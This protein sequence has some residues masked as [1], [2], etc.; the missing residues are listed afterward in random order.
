MTI[1][2]KY[3]RK[4]DLSTRLR[5]ADL[6]SRRGLSQV[7]TCNFTKKELHGRYFFVNI[8]WNFSEMLFYRTPVNGCFRTPNSLTRFKY[9]N[10]NTDATPKNCSLCTLFISYS[11]YSLNQNK[12]WV[13]VTLGFEWINWV[14]FK[15]LLCF[16]LRN[17]IWLRLIVECHYNLIIYCFKILFFKW[18]CNCSFSR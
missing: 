2:T 1:L 12:T 16:C 9:D 6:T 15:C 10:L 18:L 5:S 7:I 13:H 4:Y 8:L 14:H 17:L 3:S 11:L